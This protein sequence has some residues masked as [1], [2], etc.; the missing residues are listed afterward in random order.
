VQTSEWRRIAASVFVLLVSAAACDAVSND[1]CL[2]FSDCADGLTCAAGQCVTPPSSADASVVVTDA[3]SQAAPPSPGDE[4]D[5][6]A[7]EPEAGNAD[8]DGS[9]DASTTS[10][11]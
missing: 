10:A 5:V 3:T 8:E 1:A 2:R 11:E 4:S 6:P 9:D 7:T